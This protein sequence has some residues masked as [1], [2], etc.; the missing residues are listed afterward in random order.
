MSQHPSPDFFDDELNTLVT[1]E[2]EAAWGDVPAPDSRA[3]AAHRAAFLAAGVG[4]RQRPA[5]SQVALRYAA[6]L[7]LTLVSSFFG[8]RVVSASSLP[9]DHLYPMKLSLESVD[10]LF[11]SDE[12]WSDTQEERRL[13]EVVTMAQSGESAI[14]NFEA[15]P[16]Q[17]ADGSWYVGQIPLVVTAEQQGMLVNQCPERETTVRVYGQVL[18]GKIYPAA[19]T[20]SCLYVAFR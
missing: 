18:D 9:G 19:I 10:G 3:M 5:W 12:A 15:T 11:Y 7:V 8:A 16:T 2:L 6:I 20:P 13:A 1:N 14:V 17:H 4:I